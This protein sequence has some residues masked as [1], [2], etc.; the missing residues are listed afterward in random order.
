MGPVRNSLD[1]PQAIEYRMI[2]TYFLD[3]LRRG[4]AR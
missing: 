4:D 3:A 2:L 1:D